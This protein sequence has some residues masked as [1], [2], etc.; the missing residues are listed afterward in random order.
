MYDL[1][2]DSAA[3]PQECLKYWYCVEI[4]VEKGDIAHRFVEK[5]R[6]LNSEITERDLKLARKFENRQSWKVD[7]GQ[8][9]SKQNCRS[10]NSQKHEHNS[11]SWAFSLSGQWVTFIFW[12]KLWLDNFVSRLTDLYNISNE[13]TLLINHIW[14]G[15]S[16]LIV[17]CLWY[18]A[19][20]QLYFAECLFFPA[21][22]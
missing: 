15:C 9:I 6:N 22:S 11:L 16:T 18:Y 2:V 8:L 12:E 17:Q 5:I 13:K 4:I 3:T 19:C 7:K 20:V 21:L 1:E 14:L 10:I